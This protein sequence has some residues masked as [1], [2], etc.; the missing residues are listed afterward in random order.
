MV[1]GHED[2]DHAAEQ[3]DG[4]DPLSPGLRGDKGCGWRR[5][6]Q[7]EVGGHDDISQDTA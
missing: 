5:R 4:F 3:V 7:S 2:H 1:E 6:G